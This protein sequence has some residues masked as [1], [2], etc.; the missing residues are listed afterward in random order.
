MANNNNVIGVDFEINVGD[1]KNGLTE[2]NKL[3]GLSNSKFKAASSGMDDWTKSSEGLNAKLENLNEVYTLQKKKLNAIQTEYDKVVESQGENSEAAKRLKKQFYEQQTQVN[4]TKKDIT[5]YTSELDE[6]SKQEK[7][8]EKSAKKLSKATKE[9]GESAKESKEGFSILK[10]AIAGFVVEA[11]KA[12]ISSFSNMIE[13]SKE[14]RTELGMLEATA[15]TTGS[16]FKNAK[17][18]LVEVASITDDTGAA[19]EGLNNLMTAGFDGKAL[20]DITDALTGA[21][22]KWKDTLKFEGLAD[23]LQETLATGA[24][25]GPFS[26]LLE[27]GGQ[28][29]DVFNAGLDSCTTEAEKQ[30]YVLDQLAKLGLTE[31]KDE[32]EKA[33]KS[34]IDNNKAMLENQQATAEIGKALEPLQ[35]MLI[36]LKTKGIEALIPAV[37]KFSEIMQQVF[38]GDYSGAAENISGVFETIRTKVTDFILSLGEQLPSMIPQIFDKILALMTSNIERTTELYPKIITILTDVITSIV[39]YLPTLIDNIAT[40]LTNLLPKILEGALAMF[41]GIL[42]ALPKIISKLL[43]A[44]PK[45]IDTISQFLKNNIPTIIAAVIKLFNAIVDALP[46][47]IQSLVKALP[48]IIT[49]IIKFFTDNIPVVLDGAINLLMAIVKAIPKLI[50]TLVNDLPKII[51]AIVKGLV[52]AIPD[53]LE[54]AT[55]LL[56]SIIK[57]IPKIIIELGKEVPSIIKSIVSGLKDGISDMFSVGKDLITGL[58]DGMKESLNIVLDG[59][60]EIGSKI[61]EKVKDIFKVGSPSKVFAEIGGFLDE[62]LALGIDKNAKEA[63]DSARNLASKAVSSSQQALNGISTNNATGGLFGATNGVLGG[64]K[65][66]NYTQIINAPKSPSRIELYRQTKNLL[67]FSG[68]Q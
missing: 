64:S 40:A 34:L 68:G 17:D 37:Q 9:A 33:N 51:T 39:D 35:T 10:G 57:A 19:V 4:K 27:R 5:K 61:V 44:L 53:I 59:V 62:G 54:A 52:G 49:S 12:L 22:I 2:A 21:S 8:G 3:I 58:W 46:K 24:A 42:D 67:A 29:L 7:D 38:S 26:E 47:V 41:K 56:M 45:L 66:I 16:N 60:K 32:Y 23:G 11:G 13:E 1:L 36:N 65:N 15:N 25:V 63:I 28:N 48:K 20:D 55:K 14:L 30:N 31:V 18:N 6:V 50:S 43:A